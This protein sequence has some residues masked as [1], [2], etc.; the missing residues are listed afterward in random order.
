MKVEWL[1]ETDIFKEGTIQIAEEIE[2]QGMK[3]TYAD[4]I[5][6]RDGESYL[7]IFP[8]QA[9]VVFYGTIGFA[10]H[11]RRNAPWV[12]G[13]FMSPEKFLCSTYYAHF[14]DH[15]LANPYIMLPFGDLI[16]KKDFLFDTLGQEDTIFI[17]PDSGEKT[18]TGQLVER[19]AFERDLGEMGF[20]PI[21]PESLVVV[22]APRNIE[23][24]WRF[25]IADGDVI[26]GSRY[27]PHRLRLRPDDPDDEDARFH[28][29]AAVT[30][31]GWA[32]D[33]IWTIDIC[34]TAAGRFYVIEINSFSCSGMYACNP[35]P[36]IERA[37]R[38]A[39]EE[40]EKAH[41]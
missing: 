1:F 41:G 11:I 25:V 13:V 3:V 18:F 14:S 9:C 37:S 4:T 16:R 19:A 5:P 38:I 31:A 2:R 12:P 26:T 17:R 20:H 23:T 29:Q 21:P 36:M 39:L 35:K 33:R 6:M 22:S 40:W 30:E 7:N 24:E 32:P 34:K 8:P 15:L 28:A 27:L 10:D